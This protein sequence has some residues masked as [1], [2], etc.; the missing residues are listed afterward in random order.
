MLGRRAAASCTRLEGPQLYCAPPALL[1][2][3]LQAGVLGVDLRS[4]LTYA[5]QPGEVRILRLQSVDEE[6]APPPASFACPRPP[7]CV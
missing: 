1:G 3:S 5:F 7:Q 6:R 2:P 4:H